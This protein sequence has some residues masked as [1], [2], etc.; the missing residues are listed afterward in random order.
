MIWHFCFLDCSG[1][2]HTESSSLS[3]IG[4]THLSQKSAKTLQKQESL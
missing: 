2:P 4:L 1:M 3:D